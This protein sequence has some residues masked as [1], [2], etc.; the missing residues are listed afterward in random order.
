MPLQ[1]Q[2]SQHK[3]SPPLLEL[4]FRIFFLGAGLFAIISL[5]S[6]GAVIFSYFAPHLQQMSTSQW[7]AHEMIFGYAVAVIAGFLL[8][9]VRNW[10]GI[11][12]IVGKPLLALFC[13]WAI[14]RL[15][16][17]LGIYA[18]HIAL[19]FDM[20][21]AVFLVYSVSIPIF[22]TKQWHQLFLLT[23]LVLL[24]AANLLFYLGLFNIIDNGVFIGLYGG[25]FLV[26]AII[27]NM[28][29]RVLAFFIERGIDDPVKLWQHKW[30]DGAIYLFLIIFIS[31]YLFIHTE[32]MTNISAV[33]IAV[34]N[35]IRL[36]AWHRAG[37]W[38]RSLLWSLY[39]AF[40]F[41]NLG[42]MLF[43]ASEMLMISKSVAIHTLTVGGIGI[44]TLS[45]M[46]RISLGHTGRDV[47]QPPKGVAYI[48]A[49]M[50]VAACVRILFPIAAPDYYSWW[51]SSSLLLW[52]LAF[53]I[54]VWVYW[55][56]ISQPRPD[57]MPIIKPKN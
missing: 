13:T 52:L 26:I 14:A 2:S 31:S 45:M 36:A 5:V 43:A 41:I 35:S 21:F 3:N 16:F 51:I 7:H 9:A 48:L 15:A 8:T 1:Q 42:F 49:L 25:L 20:L 34:L 54:F 33:A 17:L 32:E 12:T 6:W 39:L 24:F 11:Q 19:W 46:C 44:F 57:T 30:L 40:W 4:G 55:P 18:V 10:T 37:I 27:F 38:R 28:A 50:L 56:I 22:K 29:R 47:S 23:K 53:C